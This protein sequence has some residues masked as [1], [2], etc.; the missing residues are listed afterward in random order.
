[1]GRSRTATINVVHQLSDV[2]Q[3]LACYPCHIMMAIMRSEDVNPYSL[4]HVVSMPNLVD[5]ALNSIK[6]F[7]YA[8]ALFKL[9]PLALI[10]LSPA[11]RHYILAAFHSLLLPT[12]ELSVIST[13]HLYRSYRLLYRSYVPFLTPLCVKLMWRMPSSACCLAATSHKNYATR[14]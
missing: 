6:G 10:E 11:V 2:L 1:M 9:Q 4:C 14:S 8:C 3:A 5:I 13:L 7:L 12:P